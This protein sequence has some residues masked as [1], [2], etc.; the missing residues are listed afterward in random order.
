MPAYRDIFTLG[1]IQET[2][3]EDLVRTFYFIH[4]DYR[5]N[6]RFPY[7]IPGTHESGT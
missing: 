4:F 3:Q 7:L 2:F 5:F 6:N 1:D